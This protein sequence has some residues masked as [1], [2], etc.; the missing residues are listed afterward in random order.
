M[1]C[2]PQHG[3]VNCTAF[4]KSTPVI[5]DQTQLTEGDWRITSNP[6]AWGNPDAEIVVLGFSKGPNASGASLAKEPHNSIAYKRK[7]ANVGKILAHVG[8]LKKGDNI[9]YNSVVDK[10]IADINGRFHFGSLIRCGVERKDAKTGEW[11]GFGS[12]MLDKFVASDFGKKVSQECSSRFLGD[13]PPKTKLIIMFG[14][15][16]KQNYVLEA[17]KLFKHARPVDWRWLEK[18]VSY[19]D[20]RITVVHVE[21]FGVLGRHLKDWLGENIHKRSIL[22]DAARLSVEIALK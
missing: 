12:N 15:G 7:R 2:L 11:K 18:D 9:F 3:R 1:S 8:L 13:L 16:K 10:A 19:T 21:H 14:L 4:F 6:L 20:G 17:Y 22:G 5:F